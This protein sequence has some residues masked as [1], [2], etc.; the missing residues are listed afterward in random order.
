MP[1]GPRPLPALGYGGRWESRREG[2]AHCLHLGYGVTG[3]HAKRA[4]PTACTSTMWAAGGSCQEGRAHRLHFGYG[5]P[6]GVMPRG[7]RPLPAPRLRGPLGVL[8]TGLALRLNPAYSGSRRISLRPLHLSGQE[9]STCSPSSCFIRWP[10][11]RN[12]T[13]KGLEG[14]PSGPCQYDAHNSAP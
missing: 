2:R 12:G 10:G 6:G 1:R 11:R 14:N 8:P 4:V 3:Y 9:W 7:P 5:A 13:G